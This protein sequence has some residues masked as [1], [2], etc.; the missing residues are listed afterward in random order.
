MFEALRFVQVHYFT[1]LEAF[2]SNLIDDGVLYLR[3]CNC[4]EDQMYKDI[5]VPLTNYFLIFGNYYKQQLAIVI[6]TAIIQMYDG[7]LL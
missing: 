6:T 4:S 1:V 5:P 7:V 3:A 2:I